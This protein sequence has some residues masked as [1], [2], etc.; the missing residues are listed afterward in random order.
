MQVYTKILITHITD[1]HF[2]HTEI[3]YKYKYTHHTEIAVIHWKHKNLTC[4]AGVH[5]DTHHTHHTEIAVIRRK[6]NNTSHA[7]QVYTKK[8]ITQIADIHCKH[9]EIADA[10]SDSSKLKS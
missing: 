10:R 6:H 8:P 5:K 2:K 3:Q 4:I 7:L 9:T 1:I